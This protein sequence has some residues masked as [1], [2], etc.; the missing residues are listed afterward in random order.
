MNNFLTEDTSSSDKVIDESTKAAIVTDTIPEK[1]NIN[2]YFV[3]NK[4]KEEKINTYFKAI[5]DKY[6]EETAKE[7]PLKNGN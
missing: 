6:L 1:M 3:V 5:Q 4:T 7:F 2:I